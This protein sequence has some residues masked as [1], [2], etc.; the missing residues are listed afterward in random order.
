VARRDALTRESIVSATREMLRTTD[1]DRLSLRKLA[2]VLGV[3]APALYAHV[4]D[5]ED[6]LRAVA[7]LGLRQ[8]VTP[9]EAVDAADP[10][11][12]LRGY[13]HAY[14]DL[15]LAD[16]EVFRVMFRYRP[17]AIEVPEIDNTLPAATDAFTLPG[18][19]VAE[20]MR[21]GAIH[22]DRDPLRVALSLW[23]TNHGVANVL[24]LGARDGE[25]V[26]PEDLAHLVDDVI[27]SMLDGLASP[28][29]PDRPPQQAPAHSTEA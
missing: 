16:P 9:K 11:E 26:I 22:P 19:A 17:D 24:L 21:T 20:A 3:T 5:K 13:G 14:V 6:L 15:A 4:R 28:P 7:E 12:R 10:L 27:D 25:V 2:G 29:R 8:H 1:L 18:A 23:A